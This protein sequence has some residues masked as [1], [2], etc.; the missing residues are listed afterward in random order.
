MNNLKFALRSLARSKGFV[1]LVVLSLGFALAVN[2]TMYTLIDAVLNPWVPYKNPEQVFAVQTRGDPREERTTHLE[3]GKAVRGAAFYS[4]LAAYTRDMPFG[5]AQV[6]TT[7]E[8]VTAYRV[9]PNMFH[10]L[11]VE[12]V[13]GRTFMSD[14]SRGDDGSVV[15]GYDLWRRLFPGRR[16]VEGATVLLNERSYVVIGV[17]PRAVAYPFR[18]NAWLLLPLSA[19]E[20]GRDVPWV[21]HVVR[22]KP[23]L[24]RE[25]AGAALA[26]V[27][28]RLAARYGNGSQP[29]AFTLRSIN[30]SPERLNDVYKVLAGS[31]VAVLLIACSNLANM[32]LARGLGRRREVAL[33]L[34]LGASRRAI[35]FQL[36]AEAILLSA[37]GGAVGLLVAAWC[38]DLLINNLPPSVNLIGTL[39]PHLSWRVFAFAV[40]AS[41]LTAVLFGLIP[42]WRASDVDVSEPL[43]ESAGTTTGRNRGRFSPIV[44]AEV[45]LSMVLLLVAVLQV[46][47]VVDWSRRQVGFDPHGLYSVNVPTG[48]PRYHGTSVASLD[49]RALN[50]LR[51]IEGVRSVAATSG[52]FVRGG[53]VM[54][55]FPSR[56]PRTATAQFYT[57]A[58]AGYLHTLGR[59]L[60]VGRDFEPGDV[61]KGAAIVDAATARWLWP[62]LNPVGHTIKLGGLES[63]APWLTVV[64]VTG[65]DDLFAGGRPEDAPDNAVVYTVSSADTVRS[66]SYIA[67]ISSTAPQAPT[68]MARELR[69]ALGL[70]FSLRSYSYDAAAELQVLA[71]R[72]IAGIFSAF[73]GFSLLL[74]SVGLYAVLTYAVSQRMREFAVRAALGADTRDLFQLVM[75]DGVVMIAGGVLAGLV[76]AGIFVRV[77]RFWNFQFNVVGAEWW[78]VGAETLL[79]VAALVACAVPAWRATRANPV[80]ILRAV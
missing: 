31:V 47:M 24:S 43:K 53:A 78:L 64:G 27:A 77:T 60:V 1:V 41:G 67:R 61:T 54:S 57:I 33:R 49:D 75:R 39:R 18:A 3:Q 6:G 20:T 5:V 4:E 68:T 40:L 59:P 9:T 46:R 19:L 26:L 45:G 34:A 72:F 21:A 76:L 25:A 69:A 32:M 51:R 2:T 38:N 48:G 28:A 37:A 8:A 58:S 62:H 12:P 11:G 65:T 16:S 17:M 22:L 14:G 15:L 10:L 70:P 42:A 13:L 35:V 71:M 36:T 66:R 63:N 55:D 80:D 7:T 50:A 52:A 44:I 29:F 74:A 79:G 73:G 23:G 56:I 30:A